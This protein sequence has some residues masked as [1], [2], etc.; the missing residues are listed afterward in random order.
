MYLNFDDTNFIFEVSGYDT[1]YDKEYSDDYWCE[2][3]VIIKNR[4]FRYKKIRSELL[5]YE[6]IDII[7]SNLK[8]LLNNEIKEVQELGFI[9]PDLFMM[10]Y[11]KFDKRNDPNLLYVKEGCEIIDICLKIEINLTESRG[12]YTGQKYTLFFGREQ[13]Q[14][15]YDYLNGDDIKIPIDDEDYSDEALEWENEYDDE[16]YDK[17]YNENKKIF[18]KSLNLAE[19]LFSDVIIIRGKDYYNYER[20]SSIEKINDTYFTKV[21]GNEKYTVAIR[22]DENKDILGLNC[23]CPCNFFCKHEYAAILEIKENIALNELSCPKCKSKKISKILWGMPNFNKALE[24]D[25]E[26]KK[27]VLGGCV[28]TGDEPEFHCNDCLYEFNLE[29]VREDLKY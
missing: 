17:L 23:T 28:I 12:F 21:L 1:E 3:S 4:N 19:E 16:Y 7:K 25:I 27:I 10:L 22:L 9:E 18:P 20:V 2:V 8:A 5:L 26:N 15:L 11:P 13:I 29:S 6:E 14:K 24:K